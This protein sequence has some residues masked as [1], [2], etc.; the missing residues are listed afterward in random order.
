MAFRSGSWLS[1][2]PLFRTLKHGRGMGSSGQRRSCRRLTPVSLFG[3]PVS[4]RWTKPVTPRGCI[5]AQFIYPLV[6]AVLACLDGLTSR[7]C[8]GFSCARMTLLRLSFASLIRSVPYSTMVGLATT[9]RAMNNSLTHRRKTGQLH[10]CSTQPATICLANTRWRP[11]IFRSQPR[12]VGHRRRDD[13]SVP[14]FHV[15][16]RGGSLATYL[17]HGT[18]HY[19][20]A[21]MISLWK[22]LATFMPK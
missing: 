1:G 6:P 14:R 21:L 22:S 17:N 5:P 12:H 10:K 3:W 2:G 19:A 16:E 11:R 15:H 7:S 20:A 8:T 18:D 4:R 13:M 9:E